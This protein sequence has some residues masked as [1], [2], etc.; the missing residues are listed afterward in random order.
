MRKNIS[1]I[2]ALGLSVILFGASLAPEGVYASNLP[3]V[4]SSQN[5]SK[6]NTEA[7]SDNDMVSENDVDSFGEEGKLNYLYLAEKSIE[8]PDSQQVLISYGDEKTTIEEAGLVVENYINKEKSY[9]STSETM[10]NTALF[11]LD[12][13]EDTQGIY[14]I[15]AV[16][17]TTADG[18]IDEIQLSD[19]GIDNVYFGVNEE[20]VLSEEETSETDASLEMQIV[21][22]DQK[23]ATNVSSAEISSAIEDALN[24]A[25]A[26]IQDLD[27]DTDI[28]TF[29]LE[30]K[31]EQAASNR[32][33]GGNLVVVL[34][35]GHDATH[36]GARSGGLNEEELTLKI[37]KY[38]K[39]EL[40]KYAGVTVYMTRETTAC[41][42]PGTSSTND[43][44]KRVDY[45]KSVGADVFV[46]IHLNS[47]SATANGAEVFYPNSSYNATIGSMGANLATQISRQLVALGLSNRGIS[48]QNSKD[49]TTYPDGSLADYYGVI[50]RSKLA[51]FPAVI[52]E[53]AFLTNASDAAFLRSEENLKKL[54]IADANGIAAYYGLSESI[55]VKSGAPYI[56]SYD[57]ASGTFT[58]KVDGVTPVEKITSV[59]YAV[60][61]DVAGQA[62][63]RWYTA[64]NKGNGS[65]EKSI[66][67]A[68]FGAQAGGYTIHTY[69]YDT[70]GVAHFLGATSCSMQRVA[71]MMSGI[72]ASVAPDE[73]TV[74]ITATGV[75]QV[76][77][78]KFAVW[79]NVNGQDDLIW[80]RA[81]NRGN[82]TWSV[83]VP[84]TNH[85]GSSGIYNVHAYGDNAYVINRFLKNT[86]FA[87]NGPNPG[88]VT[89][90][91]VNKEAGTFSVNITGAASNSGITRINVAVWSKGDQSNLRWYSATRQNDGSYQIDVNLTNHGYE[92][93][94]YH[95]HAY[96]IDGN[97]C[98]ALTAGDIEI[99]QPIA[100]LTAKGNNTQTVYSVTATGVGYPGGVR[101]VMI[102]AWSDING[103]DDIIWY[104]A[105]N[106]GNGTWT[107]NV[108]IANHKSA[109]SYSVHMYIVD[110]KGNLHFGAAT[111]FKVDA[112]TAGKVNIK[113]VDNGAGKFTVEVAG[114]SSVS[115]VADVK[116]AVWS[117]SDQSN[118][119][120]YSAVKQSDGSY[121]V[122][123][124]IASHGY[125]YGLYHA[126]AYVTTGNGISMLTA[127]NVEMKQ[128]AA[129]LKVSGDPNQITYRA[130]ASDVGYP[131]G[132]KEVKIAVWSDINGQDDLIWY[133]ATNN[134]NGNWSVNIPVANHRSAGS[135]SAHMYIVDRNGVWHFGAA[136]GFRVDTPIAGKVLIKN[137][138]N[139]TGTFTVEVAG[140]SS[141]SG[142]A[143]VNVAVWSKSDQSNIRWYAA[144][145][146]SDGTY[147][148]NVNIASHG[149]EYGVYHAHAYIKTGN[150]IS[151]LTASD[152][153]IKQP[154]AVLTATGSAN[155]SLYNVT[156]TDV[157]YAGGVKEVKFAIWSDDGGQ[158]DLIWYN[159]T[160][161]GNGKWD[162]NIP[163]A[164]HRS[165]GSYSVHM[166]IVDRNGVWH[167]GGATGFRVD[168]ITA[169]E[170]VVV[171]KQESDGTFGVRVNGVA[172]ISGVKEVKVAVWCAPNQ[173]DIVWYT[174]TDL[175][176]SNYQIVAD[177]RNH[178]ANTGIY[179]AHVYVTGINGAVSFAGNT[180]CSMIN[181]TN[182]LHPIMG[183]SSVTVDQMVNYY[184]SVTSYPAYYAGTEAPTI[185]Q[186][187]QI[188]LDECNAEGVK[189]EVAFVQA[190]KETNFL[191]YTGD[192]RIEQFNFAGLG[193]TGNGVR[194]DSF[195]SVTVGIRAQIQHLKAYASDAPL[196]QACVDSRF[197]YVQRKTAPFCE[198]LGIKENPFGKGW[199][200]AVN[201]GYNIVERV[202]QLKRY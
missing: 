123:V 73:K 78:L 59:N 97:G 170:V 5:T 146:Q 190:M 167:F 184:N 31:I 8:T 23:N 157:G 129:S 161:H 110:A 51:G 191:R 153:E 182:V 33:V 53:H 103:Q 77:N 3:S 164:N 150:G 119:R 144:T 139:G 109:G 15:V 38:C 65:F 138:N 2:I 25:G 7:V 106:Q 174:A 142:I 126:H 195:A 30:G 124:N 198:W 137:V 86:S 74:T 118:I 165:V 140:A 81:Q 116:V 185:R 88:K 152:V 34:D 79:S 169:N 85:R 131:G 159:A 54:G 127:G 48:I 36:A 42:Y 199:A 68:D 39:A 171:D 11:T 19:T 98:S 94:V 56:Q 66:N 149:Y 67:I 43:N 168:P 92:Y 22:F 95:A 12:F 176:G 158:D 104:E 60:W 200:T 32:S 172:S 26:D 112:P 121:Q 193:A 64:D 179:Q 87:I 115:G 192:V 183:S 80:Y 28:S 196:T 145:L 163:I 69:A 111:T 45:A 130:I 148:A 1:K 63:L 90:K 133:N 70:R 180:T 105:T 82:G 178:Q 16:K 102:A 188:Y 58:V 147:R 72:Q 6:A 29:S 141:V 122:N 35:P 47:G 37:A 62:S 117:K 173:S 101:E 194:G 41:P 108:P 91:N 49:G 96:V 55:D 189:A 17:V 114:I 21:S 197:R 136:T 20:L 61:S 84:I 154:K 187:C 143:D 18:A 113:N 166:Y 89:F 83:V 162:M 14:E 155:Q 13:A 175:G 4:Q 201:Y 186:F 75:A 40:E 125:E 44:A 120:W 46:S 50:R 156:A 100:G 151:M 107:A 71:P 181:V 135:Y 177:V 128:P 57:N 99:K 93:G 202:N 27:N 10:D 76:S 160:S 24:D 52:V 132:V 9:F 134:A